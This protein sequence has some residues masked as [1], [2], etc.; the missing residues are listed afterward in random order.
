MTIYT[1]NMCMYTHPYLQTHMCTIQFPTAHSDAHLVNYRYSQKLTLSLFLPRTPTLCLALTCHPPPS[2]PIPT[3]HPPVSIHMLLSK[4]NDPYTKIRL[5]Y[6]C[7]SV[8]AQT[9]KWSWF[10]LQVSRGRI[11]R[12]LYCGSVELLRSLHQSQLQLCQ[13]SSPLVSHVF[14][15]QPHLL[16]FPLDKRIN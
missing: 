10:H 12:K 11:R 7:I 15:R 8:F 2:P 1:Y 14:P 16:P 13:V 6:Y 4:V 5:L 9:T 3:P